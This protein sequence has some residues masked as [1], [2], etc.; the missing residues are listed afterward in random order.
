MADVIIT[1]KFYRDVKHYERKHIDVS[2]VYILVDYFRADLPIPKEYKPHNLTGNFA[3]YT[4]CHIKNDILLLYVSGNGTITLLRLTS[5]DK[6][7]K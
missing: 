3:G 7:F 1:S 2:E 6:L 5:H 4:E